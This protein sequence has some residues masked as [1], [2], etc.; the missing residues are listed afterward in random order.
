M[1]HKKK[2]ILVP[3]RTPEEK[4]SKLLNIAYFHFMNRERLLF[5][6][7]SD[8]IPFLDNLLW[9]K[10]KDEFLPHTIY[11]ESSYDFITITKEFF[12]VNNSPFIFNLHKESFLADGPHAV[13]YEFNDMTST[14]KQEI[15]QKKIEYYKQNSL[16]SPLFP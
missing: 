9:T 16:F 8:A 10:K 12:N 7:P 5:I 2:V 13:I 3:I 6:T 4:L 15:S 14:Q 11:N 1:T